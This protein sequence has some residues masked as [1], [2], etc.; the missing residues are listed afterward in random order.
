M[1]GEDSGD[2]EDGGEYVESWDGEHDIDA[3]D[4]YLPAI[5]GV[6]T[7]DRPILELL[8]QVEGD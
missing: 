8:A 6:A 5:N 2:D 1:F 4:R 7:S 3:F